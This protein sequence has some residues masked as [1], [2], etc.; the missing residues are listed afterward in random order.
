M[1]LRACG[2]RA[3]IAD[4]HKRFLRAL[5][6]CCPAVRTG[7]S[8]THLFSLFSFFFLVTCPAPGFRSARQILAVFFATRAR[9]YI[10]SDLHMFYTPRGGRT[11][12]GSNAPGAFL[13]LVGLV[14]GGKSR[15]SSLSFRS[16]IVE[17]NEQGRERARK[18]PAQTWR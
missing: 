9:N 4:R 10:L 14:L 2:A 11:T 16:G 8:N 12:A 7:S 5:A 13:V 15:P 1:T 17:R 3:E 6:C 18:S